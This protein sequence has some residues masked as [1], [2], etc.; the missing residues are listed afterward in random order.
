MK[1]GEIIKKNVHKIVLADSETDMKFFNSIE[2][3]VEKVVITNKHTKKTKLIYASEIEN[4][5][6]LLE[7]FNV[8]DL[9]D[10]KD[11]EAFDDSKWCNFMIAH[12]MISED[13]FMRVLTSDTSRV[14]IPNKSGE[15]LTYSAF[16]ENT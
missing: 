1:F 10:K 14:Y 7:L 16:F 9:L 12:G 2:D 15:H 13:G 3:N 8:R 11:G 4:K 6:Y 5:D